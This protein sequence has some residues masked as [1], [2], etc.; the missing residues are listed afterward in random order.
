MLLLDDRPHLRRLDAFKIH[1][2]LK[3]SAYD[4]LNGA[5]RSGAALWHQ[6][7]ADIVLLIEPCLNEISKDTC[8]RF[9]IETHTLFNKA[10]ACQ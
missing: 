1:I 4:K 6:G 7:E 5:K 3:K 8:M 2:L 10:A 9:I